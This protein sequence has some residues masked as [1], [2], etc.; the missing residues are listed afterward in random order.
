MSFID[1]WAHLLN[2]SSCIEPSTTTAAPS[3]SSTAAP[4]LGRRR[5]EIRYYN[6]GNKILP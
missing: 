5:R 2:I 3:S 6:M 1:P 4:S